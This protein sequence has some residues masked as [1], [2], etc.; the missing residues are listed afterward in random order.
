RRRAHLLT[1][2]DRRG[3]HHR[4]GS[5]PARKAAR[6]DHRPLGRVPVRRGHPPRQQRPLHH[7]PLR[8]RK[9]SAEQQ[10]SVWRAATRSSQ[11]TLSYPLTKRTP[12]VIMITFIYR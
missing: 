1:P 3:R 9:R 6:K 4:L 2:R 7:L 12:L 8:L 5:A 10:S 11:K